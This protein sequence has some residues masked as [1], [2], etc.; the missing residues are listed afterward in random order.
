MSILRMSWSSAFGAVPGR[1][2]RP[3]LRVGWIV[4]SVAACVVRAQALGQTSQL[5]P[6]EVKAAFLVNL[7]K[8][9][10][11][12]DTVFPSNREPIAF[13]IVGTGPLANVLSRTVYG[14]SIRGRSLTVRTYNVGDDLRR[15]Q[16]LFITASEQAR[17]PQILASVAGASVLTVSEV[18]R[19]AEEGGVVQFAVDE[20]RVHFSV[21]HGAALQ[22]KLQISAKLLTL[23]RVI[24][25][26]GVLGT[27]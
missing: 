4:F 13:G 24:N 11:W 10:E 16:V 25:S 5:T 22:A 2:V 8:F 23:S 15:C 14:Q 17:V 1:R 12:P 26:P 20:D 3:A 27:K 7:V 9:V 6:T 18:Q 19:F 21:N